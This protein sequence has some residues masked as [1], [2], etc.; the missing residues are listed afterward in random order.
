MHGQDVDF[1]VICYVATQNDQVV[2]AGGLSWQHGLCW[3]WL[4]MVQPDMRIHAIRI[5]R[6]AKR[7]LKTARQYGEAEVYCFRDDH[8][9]SKR[10]LELVGFEFMA[11]EPVI[12]T[13]GSAGE[14]EIWKWQN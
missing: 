3:I 4:G 10:L 8:L 13:D 5:V 11:T 1:P 9:N 7:M 12:F 14:K 2:A 6:W